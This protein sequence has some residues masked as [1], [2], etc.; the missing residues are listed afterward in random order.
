VGGW[1]NV[2]L[3]SDPKG[4]QSVV[5]KRLAA[6][7]GVKVPFHH[8]DRGFAGPLEDIWNLKSA[9]FVIQS[10]GTFSWVGA[11]LSEAKEVTACLMWVGLFYEYMP[12]TND[13]IAVICLASNCVSFLSISGWEVFSRCISFSLLFPSLSLFAPH[14]HHHPE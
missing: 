9:K 7:L 13:L 6:E 12:F 11:F 4:H 3:L 5:A 2:W 1:D 14:H 8:D 10:Y